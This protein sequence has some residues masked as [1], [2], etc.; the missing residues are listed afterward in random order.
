MSTAGRPA[1]VLARSHSAVQQPLHGA[2]RRRSRERFVIQPR[3]RIVDDQIGE[4][5]YVGLQRG[6]CLRQVHRRSCRHGFSRRLRCDGWQCPS[7]QIQCPPGL[8]MPKA[9]ADVFDRIGEFGPVPA[10][11]DGVGRPATG[12]LSGVLYGHREVKPVE[13]MINGPG[14]RGLSQR[15][16]AVGAVAQDRQLGGRGHAETGQHAIQLE[17][18]RIPYVDGPGSCKPYF[19]CC[20]GATGE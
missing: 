16:W 13:Y 7:D 12:T 20:C 18:I 6:Q 11:V 9:P 5:G 14:A 10:V 3:R 15:L 4:T 1:H 8:A 17:S 2:L 19:P